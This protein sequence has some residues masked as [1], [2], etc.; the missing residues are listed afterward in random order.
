M[1]NLAGKSITTI[2]VASCIAVYLI[3]PEQYSDP[4][5]ESLIVILIGTVYGQ[6]IFAAIWS[7]LGPGPTATRMM[8]SLMWIGGLVLALYF[9][10]GL[11]T[12]YRYDIPLRFGLTLLAY[13]LIT[14]AMLMV[15]AKIVG[16]EIA[17][18]DAP[19]DPARR[20]S[21]QFTIGHVLLFV[22]TVGLFLGGSRLFL[23]NLDHVDLYRYWRWEFG[24]AIWMYLAA[25]FLFPEL[26]FS[27]LSSAWPARYFIAS[28]L[29]VTAEGLFEVYL[30]SEM[31]YARLDEAIGIFLY[32][33]CGH[34]VATGWMAIF[35]LTLRT[36]GYRVNFRYAD[37]VPADTAAK[38]A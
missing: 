12:R 11:E 21:R 6:G 10:P 36:A 28:V 13:W 23:L 5:R 26:Y 9:N 30:A 2:A 27:L 16:L 17:K 18:T 35:G 4:W 19:I 32:V 34:V 7:A 33:F 1:R 37:T 20:L 14:Q 24:I 3:R 22:T 38:A 31:F 8:A 15:F 29:F 25:L